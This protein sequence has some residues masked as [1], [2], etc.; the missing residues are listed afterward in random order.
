MKA[1]FLVV[2]FLTAST[3][4]AQDSTCNSA[5]QKVILEKIEDF[6]IKVRAFDKDEN[7]DTTLKYRIVYKHQ[8][9]Q[10]Q[11][12]PKKEWVNT[13]C[14]QE[15]ANKKG[16]HLS[17]IKAALTK[18]ADRKFKIQSY[19]QGNYLIMTSLIN[20]EGDQ[21]SWFSS[22]SYYFEKSAE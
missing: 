20:Y 22:H 1:F 5:K 18:I 9:D 15:Y 10:R 21:T 6:K 4:F 16:Q 2:A 12:L 11:V 3:A 19:Q 7:I 14:V 8:K 13:L 17:D